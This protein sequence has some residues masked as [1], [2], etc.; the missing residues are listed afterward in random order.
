MAHS[1]S[2]IKGMYNVGP[3]YMKNLDVFQYAEI[4]FLFTA[5]NQRV[6]SS[7]GGVENVECSNSKL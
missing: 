2:I 5:S 3:I 7:I 1:F 6:Y 4:L